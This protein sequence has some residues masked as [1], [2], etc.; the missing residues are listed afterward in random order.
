[1]KP[2]AACTDRRRLARF[3]REAAQWAEREL[4]NGFAAY[5]PYYVG[6]TLEKHGL[7]YA[8]PVYRKFVDIFDGEDAGDDVL[9]RGDGV[10]AMCFMAAMVEAGDA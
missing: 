3:L 1:M 10:L 4:A 6:H 8:G 7:R 9:L 5:G 2:I